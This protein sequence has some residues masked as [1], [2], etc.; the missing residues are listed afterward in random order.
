MR[1][2]LS[3]AIL[4]FALTLVAACAPMGGSAPRSSG[5]ASVRCLNP[6]DS[7]GTGAAGSSESPDRP[8]FFLFC[9]QSP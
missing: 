6:G 1:R 3:P 4:C 9:A 2:F 8:I 5:G 7:G